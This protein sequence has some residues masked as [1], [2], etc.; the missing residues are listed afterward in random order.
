[1]YI[2]GV[3]LGGVAGAVAAAASGAVDTF[4]YVFFFFSDNLVFEK[5]VVTA[6]HSPLQIV[7]HT[8]KPFFF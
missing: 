1:M 7:S 4:R 8:L 2:E 6:K 3:M 5:A